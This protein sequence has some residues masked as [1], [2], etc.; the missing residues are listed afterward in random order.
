[1]KPRSGGG[2]R[3][4]SRKRRV[5]ARPR[6]ST[7]SPSKSARETV[8][9]TVAQF[10]KAVER[11]TSELPLY[12]GQ[13]ED[14]PLLPKLSR[15]QARDSNVLKNERTL[16]NEFKRR[17]APFLDRTPAD[18]WDWLALAQHHGMAT[19][20][21]DWTSN[22]LI[23]LWFA[24]WRPMKQGKEGVVYAFDVEPEDMLSPNGG[25]R[26]LDPFKATGTKVYQPNMVTSRIVAQSGWFTV[27]R[28]EPAKKR[29]VAFEDD[30]KYRRR[31]RKLVIPGKRFADIRY[32]LDQMGT[33]Q[34]ALFPDL[35]GVAQYSEW[36]H[37]LSSDEEKSIGE[38]RP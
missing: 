31:I 8:I 30:P 11:D 10:V 20:L 5:A 38:R 2:G 36:L 35:D 13:E 27:H 25:P 22:P 9:R 12:R 16:L 14:W 26:R 1:M 18:E 7:S 34:G 19:R 4:G 32:F 3:S 23:A 28:F 15:V 33:N 24:V 37:T 17:A 6:P 29:F 21:L